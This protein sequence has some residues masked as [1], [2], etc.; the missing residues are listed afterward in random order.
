[1]LD[2]HN[3]SR[4]KFLMNLAKTGAILP[5]ANQLM[6]Q[7][8]FAAG[9]AKNVLFLYTPNGH[10]QDGWDPTFTGNISGNNEL[11]F[12]LAPLKEWNSK[13][14]ILKDIQVSTRPDG[15]GVEGGHSDGIKGCLTGNMDL[16]ASGA[17]IDHMIA[18][19]LNQL[20]S[21]SPAEVLN[22]GV[23]T[24]ESK[25][26][27][28]SQ[29][30]GSGIENRSIPDNNPRAVMERLKGKMNVVPLN[31]LEKSIYDAILTDF[32]DLSSAMLEST[33]AT[34]INE[35][36][37]ALTR[38]RDRVNFGNGQYIF[39]PN[40]EADT[41]QNKVPTDE[42]K[43]RFPHLVKAQIDNVVGAFANGLHRVATLQI[44]A[45]DNHDGYVNYFFSE[46]LAMN[47]LAKEQLKKDDGGGDFKYHYGHTA[48]H[49]PGWHSV[50]G[51]ARWHSSM[52]AYAMD[53]LDQQGILDETLI[54]VFSEVGDHQH[55]GR[56]GSIVVAG[57]AGGGLPMGRVINC[58]RGGHDGN[59]VQLF[60]DIA[61][62]MGAT[63]IGSHWKTGLI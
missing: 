1:M 22:I 6:G 61:R 43:L 52:L 38:L 55:N 18:S 11:S 42:Q 7:K 60:G 9:T 59:T 21:A 17:S 15:S 48:S 8:A 62:H 20:N 58:N 26:K 13:L 14:I 50:H 29:S 2:L 46:C 57:G 24:S 3:R 41:T 25:S 54:V 23:R 35:H 34:K 49:E 36:K 56:H 28:I 63:N 31:P 16:G 4:R 27:I 51:Q 33:R 12:A 30:F 37:N 40:T 53:Q 45:G 5:F 19:R 47:Q 32:D 39:N 10:V 44:A